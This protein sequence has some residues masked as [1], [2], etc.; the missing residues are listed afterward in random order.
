MLLA[1]WLIST[2]TLVAANI[3]CLLNTHRSAPSR[4]TGVSNGSRRQDVNELSRTVRLPPAET[5]KRVT[6]AFTFPALQPY[7]FQI[8]RLL[9]SRF[10]RMAPAPC[11]PLPPV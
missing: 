8:K 9:P 2:D 1:N 4:K 3:C 5:S 11:D 10:R 7:W 6:Q